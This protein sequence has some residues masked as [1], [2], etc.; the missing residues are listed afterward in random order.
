MFSFATDLSTFYLDD[1]M[2]ASQNLHLRPFLAETG[3]FD[4]IIESGQTLSTAISPLDD[5]SAVYLKAT[6]CDHE[7]RISLLTEL[8]IIPGI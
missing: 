4:K 6:V 8:V 1:N 7:L 5:S 3:N 2:A